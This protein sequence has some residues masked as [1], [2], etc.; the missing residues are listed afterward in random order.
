M[1]SW[2][3]FDIRWK[4]SRTTEF[5]TSLYRAGL[6]IRDLNCKMI[7]QDLSE[8]KG[9]IHKPFRAVEAFNFYQVVM[10][11]D[12]QNSEIDPLFAWAPNQFIKS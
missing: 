6:V 9:E 2:T 4:Y 1:I 12:S 11:I 10:V 5:R 7:L 8:R 3:Y